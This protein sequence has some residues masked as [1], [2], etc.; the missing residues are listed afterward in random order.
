MVL[1]PKAVRV[2]GV[3]EAL[4]L[5]P[6]GHGGGFGYEGQGVGATVLSQGHGGGKAPQ[7]HYDVSL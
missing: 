1:S 3:G 6:Y 2:H 5:L 4:G 7:T